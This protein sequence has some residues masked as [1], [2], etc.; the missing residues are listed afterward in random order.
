M[1]ASRQPGFQFDHPLY[2]IKLNIPFN[3]LHLSPTNLISPHQQ[4]FK[5]EGLAE[6][7]SFEVI[8]LT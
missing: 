4:A 1:P 6:W 8:P 2:A 3:Q 5:I 7:A